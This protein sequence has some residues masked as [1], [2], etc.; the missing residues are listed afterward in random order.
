MKIQNQYI[1]I[2]MFNLGKIRV[3]PKTGDVF[4]GKNDRITPNILNGY[5]QY[6][7]SLGYSQGVFTSFGHCL[8][9]LWV[10]GTY[11]PELV[12]DH[13][14]RDRGNNSIHNLRCI[15]QSENTQHLPDR[16]ERSDKGNFKRVRYPKDV[17]ASMLELSRKGI[18]D[19]KIAAQFGCARQTVARIVD[20]EWAKTGEKDKTNWLLPT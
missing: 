19:I 10:Y 20:E 1:A 5:K 15:T 12:I 11:D 4:I 3:D 7:V 8:V 17:K 18:S 6:S 13:R 2:A 9:Y 16:K 14:D